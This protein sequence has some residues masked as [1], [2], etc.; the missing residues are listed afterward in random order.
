MEA[1]DRR[2]Q[3]KELFKTVIV[4]V[5]VALFVRIFVL[6]VYLVDGTSMFPTLHDQEYLFVNKFIYRFKDP[7]VGEIIVFKFA[8]DQ[9]KDFIK[10]VIAI[11]GQTIEIKE[12][13][14]FI[15]G[16]SVNE[17]FIAEQTL[18][19]YGPV[20]IPEGK[21]FVLGD[22]RNH[23]SDSRF[24]EVGFIDP[25]TIQG[26]TFFVFWPLSNAKKL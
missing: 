21:Y 4:A 22:N 2:N 8:G 25:D 3:T 15:D 26:K 20:K 1:S 18:G 16:K 7:E 5:I 6:E 11:G 14:V 10:R 24:P 23:S 13:L 9:K 12:G 17:T 19:H